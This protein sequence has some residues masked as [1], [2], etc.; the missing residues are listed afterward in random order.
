VPTVL[1]QQSRFG[2][3]ERKFHSRRRFDGNR[4]SGSPPCSESTSNPD[5]VPVRV[6]ESKW[7]ARQ[8]LNLE[9]ADYEPDAL[10]VELRAPMLLYRILYLA[11]CRVSSDPLPPCLGFGESR[12]PAQCLR[13]HGAESLGCLYRRLAH[14]KTRPR[15]LP[16]PVCVLAGDTSI[17]AF[18]RLDRI[19]EQVRAHET[20]E[21]FG[22]RVASK[23][24][25]H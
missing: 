23:V 19:P 24:P 2:K 25:G 12:T 15:R 11:S 22:W 8:D 1:L 17:F 9:P 20:K 13:P 5:A 21:R 4:A 10:T 3:S 18:S 14:G 6:M 16:D 7:W